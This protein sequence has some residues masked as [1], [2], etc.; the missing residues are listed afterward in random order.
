MSFR[1]DPRYVEVRY[2]DLAS[3]PEQT[4]RELMSR[5]GEPWDEGML[6]YHTVQSGSRDPARFPQTPEAAGAL[7]TR[8][9]GRWQRDMTE[10][11][12][13]VFKA[14]AGELLAELGYAECGDW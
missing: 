14:T 5:V 13:A 12:K 10:P 7:R 3:R 2:E 11:D 8:S 1:N 4:L 9:V 6:N